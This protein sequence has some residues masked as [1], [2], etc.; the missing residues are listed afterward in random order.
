MDRPDQAPEI[1]NLTETKLKM[2]SSTV[3]TT[4]STSITSPS[5]IGWV[6]AAEDRRRHFAVFAEPRFP[7]PI[8][9]S[10]GSQE[11]GAKGTDLIEN[12][13]GGAQSRQNHQH[14]QHPVHDPILRFRSRFG[15][16]RHP[17]SSWPE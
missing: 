7:P 4:F 5:A 1:R 10:S 6:I 16:P 3:P 14:V 12:H 15:V 9:D 8:K 2:I 11:A 17:T 13:Q